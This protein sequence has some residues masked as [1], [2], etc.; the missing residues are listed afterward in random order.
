MED[1]SIKLFK[2]MLFMEDSFAPL[3]GND[4]LIN[5]IEFPFYIS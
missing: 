4:K 5:D 3:W 2:N 1:K